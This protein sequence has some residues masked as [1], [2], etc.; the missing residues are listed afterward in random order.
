MPEPI[1]LAERI[2]RQIVATLSAVAGVGTVFRYGQRACGDDA[3]MEQAGA[4]DVIVYPEDEQL[5]TADATP[6]DYAEQRMPLLITWL[7]AYEDAPAVNLPTQRRRAQARLIAALA[8]DPQ[9]TEDATDEQLAVDSD[10]VGVLGPEYTEGLINASV[11]LS[12]LYR[13]PRSDPYTGDGI[14]Q[15]TE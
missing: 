9:I 11:R 3:D 2:E 8:V 1:P 5:T 14:T 10:I 4:G 15:Q 13:H 12:V 7:V 6:F